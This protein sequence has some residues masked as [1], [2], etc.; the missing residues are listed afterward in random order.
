MGNAKDV[1][2]GGG[3]MHCTGA[4]RSRSSR[5]RRSL[6]ASRPIDV[7]AFTAEDRFGEPSQTVNLL[8]EHLN[9]VR[10]GRPVLPGSS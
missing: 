8:S 6:G 9:H 1:P 5:A 10:Q 2:S 4:A 7:S 3:L